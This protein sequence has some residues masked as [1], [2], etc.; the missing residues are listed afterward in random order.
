M[1]TLELYTRITSYTRTPASSSPPSQPG[2]ALRCFFL[3]ET[4]DCDRGTRRRSKLSHKI[5]LAN[6]YVSLTSS[7]R[8]APV[9]TALPDG[10]MP[11]KISRSDSAA[12]CPLAPTTVGLNLTLTPV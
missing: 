8:T 7:H 11:M 9:I 6:S 10:N 12:F 4:S 2:P 3:D 5:D 1:A